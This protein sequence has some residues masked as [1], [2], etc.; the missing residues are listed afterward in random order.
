MNMKMDVDDVYEAVVDVV[1][2]I[3]ERVDIC[4]DEAKGVGNKQKQM[5]QDV[6]THAN[7]TVATRSGRTTIPRPQLQFHSPPD[8]SNQP[9]VPLPYRSNPSEV[10]L[11]D[12]GKYPHPYRS[13]IEN[14]NYLPQQLERHSE[15]VFLPFA[16]TPLQYV[17]TEQQL[18]ELVTVLHSHSEI[19]IDLEHHSLRSF[20]GFTCLMQISTRSRDYLVDTITL[21]HHIHKLAPIFADPTKVKV[22]HGADSDIVWLQKDFDIYV[23]NLFDT[24]QAARVL[25]FPSFGLA[26]LLKFYCDVDV[27]KKYQLADWRLRPLPSDMIHYARSDTHYLLYVYDR[28]TNQLI[29]RGN[30][31]RNLLTL[32]YR[33]SANLTLLKYEKE[34]LTPIAYKQLYHK[35]PCNFTDI[36]LAVFAALFRWR[37]QIAAEEDESTR[38]VMPNYML[39]NIA[40]T[41]PTEAMHL[42]ALCSPVPPL[43]RIHAHDICRIIREAKANPSQYHITATTDTTTPKP[44]ANITA[45]SRSLPIPTPSPIPL[46]ESFNEMVDEPAT[47]I[48]FQRRKAEQSTHQTLVNALAEQSEGFHSDSRFPAFS[49]VCR[50][51]VPVKIFEQSPE[52]QELCIVIKQRFKQA[53]DQNMNDTVNVNAEVTDE[54]EET[55]EE[56]EKEE[57]AESHESLGEEESVTQS[58]KDE[59]GDANTPST[60][61]DKLGQKKKKRRKQKHTPLAEESPAKIANKS[62]HEYGTTTSTSATPV[63]MLLE[64]QFNLPKSARG[65]QRGSRNVG[66]NL[67]SQTFSFNKQSANQSKWSK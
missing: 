25:D 30:S 26:Y 44:S 59:S 21:R 64:Q 52:A 2:G 13:E 22:M 36:Q 35:T 17:D 38:Y 39:F 51:S 15:Q 27:D 20:Q 54:V 66:A 67:K 46:S 24:G 65:K 41:M 45:V 18:D 16:D 47:P 48:Q 43:V 12:D 34:L 56:T 33:N 5:L 29:E 4:I 40:D 31:L 11:E 1:D 10:A 62:Q 7:D 19:A 55:K 6:T 32:V 60:I 42:I 61:A 53:M 58:L 8:N 49:F 14:L 28:M 57:A 63:N 3:L 9:F 23:V 37:Y 50:R